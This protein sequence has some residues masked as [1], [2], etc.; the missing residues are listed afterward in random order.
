M[1]STDG[2]AVTM[3][4]DAMDRMIEQTRGS[5]HTEVVY[6]P[7]GMKL[8]LMNGQTL[9]QAFV[10]L[11]G[12][13]RAVYSSS[14]LAYYRHSDHLGSSRLATTPTRT[15]YYDV[16]Y[17]PYGEDY[18]GSGTTPDLSFTDEHQDTVAGG[19]STNLYDFMFRE[20][21]AGHG[22]WTSPD[23]AGLGVADAANPQTWNRYSYVQNN[24]SLWIDPLGLQDD[25]VEI[26]ADSKCAAGSQDVNGNCIRCPNSTGAI[27]VDGQW[28]CGM[29]W[30]PPPIIPPPGC[31]STSQCGPGGQTGSDGNN[32]KP[33]KPK[34]AKPKKP[35]CGAAKA[36][37]A[38]IDRQAE[39]M[40]KM[41]AKELGAGFAIGCAAGFIGTESVAPVVGTPLAVG[42]CAIGAVGGLITAEG[43]FIIANLGDAVSQAV[44]EA[45]AVV[46][47]VQD[48]F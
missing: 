40:A 2:T 14:G 47:V 29:V 26:R 31:P 19:W 22:R 9:V 11:P 5:S 41:N 30:L 16:A 20:Y 17:A 18:N 28:I 25:H 4:Y 12:G 39:P 36:N 1:L 23:P 34:P 13:S 3:I 46:Q 48:C 7:Y 42:D 32:G 24:P 33:A 27:V 6:G 21:R 45:K 10:K 38:A 43:V 44:A 35:K 37:V 15:K 8:A